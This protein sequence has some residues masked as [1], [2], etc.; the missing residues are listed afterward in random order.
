PQGGRV[1]I[2][3]ATTVVGRR[4]LARYP[5][6]RPG[7][8]VLITISEVRRAAA[9]VAAG[10][11]AP[12]LPDPMDTLARP[13]VDLGALL[14]LVGGCGGHLWMEAESSGNMTIRIHLPR[15]APE[16]GVP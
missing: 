12:A 3:L 1:R 13:G 16:T 6:V 4:F 2:D 5:N 11:A 9:A 7:P 8:H 14:G 15:C 10:G